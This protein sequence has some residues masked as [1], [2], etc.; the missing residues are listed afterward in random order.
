MV[1][2]RAGFLARADAFVDY[3]VTMLMDSPAGRLTRPLVLMLAYGFQ[4]PFANLADASPPIPV[5]AFQREPFVPLRQR[6]ARKLAWTGA[7]LSAAAF[8]LMTLLVS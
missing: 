8:A 3:S 5:H 4:R 1:T 7:G 6:L 2:T